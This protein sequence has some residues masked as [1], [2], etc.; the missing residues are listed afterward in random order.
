MSEEIASKTGEIVTISLSSN[1]TTGFEWKAEYDSN[2]L[3]FV[4]KD[5]FP[6][7]N[8]LG[9]GGTEI[10]KFEAL[11]EGTTVLQMTYQRGSETANS[12]QKLYNI[13]IV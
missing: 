13:Q 12:K 4:K 6:S 2:F 1:P 9:A 8:L 7:S 10:F 3:K 11:K 5:Y